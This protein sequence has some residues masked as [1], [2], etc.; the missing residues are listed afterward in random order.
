MAEPIP[1]SE[2]TEPKAQGGTETKLTQELKAIAEANSK[3]TTDGHLDDMEIHQPGAEMSNKEKLAM[4]NLFEK[5]PEDQ[6]EV[7]VQIGEGESAVEVR[8]CGEGN[9]EQL[10]EAAEIALSQLERTF[11]RPLNEIFPGLKIYFADDIIDGGGLALAEENAIILDTVKQSLTL[12][13]T[14]KKLVEDE[15]L[16][17]GD[18]SSL[19]ESPSTLGAQI[20][21]VH[22]VGHILDEKVNGNQQSVAF[23][24][25]NQAE[26][27]TLYGSFAA[28]EDY[29]ESFTYLVIGQDLDEKRRQIIQSDITLAAS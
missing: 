24:G 1:G 16:H 29:A 7:L 6:Q 12:E 28:H 3:A 2:L 11:G 26:S 13:E 14:E 27:P 17:P 10:T 19:G 4:R 5:Y 25:L 23:Q 8:L 20:T 15:I 21:I 9:N 18:W 22:E